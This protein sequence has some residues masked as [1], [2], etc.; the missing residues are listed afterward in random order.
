MVFV[1]NGPVTFQ[2]AKAAALGSSAGAP[3]STTYKVPV[4]AVVQSRSLSPCG[5]F[6]TVSPVPLK[7]LC[8]NT[9]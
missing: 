7:M 3:K 4:A 8:A 2:S 5:V 9:T 1:V 6:R